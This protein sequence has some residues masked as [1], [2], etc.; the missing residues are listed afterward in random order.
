VIVPAMT[1]AEAQPGLR[2][3]LVVAEGVTPTQGYYNAFL[4]P[5]P[6]EEDGVFVFE[7]RVL[8]P[9]SPQLQ[10]V[11]PERTRRV[12]AS[13]FLSVLEMRGVRAI[14]IVAGNTVTI[15]TPRAAAPRTEEPLDLMVGG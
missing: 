11:G 5:M 4:L 3:T 8:A 13:A 1:R 7:F 9:R 10:S 6:T 14:R 12:T 2:G 15:P